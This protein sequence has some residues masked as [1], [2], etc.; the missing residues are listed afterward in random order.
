MAASC[1]SLRATPTTLGHY[2]AS[3]LLLLMYMLM[4]LLLISKCSLAAPP[5]PSPAGKRWVVV[6]DR[7]AEKDIHGAVGNLGATIVNAFNITYDGVAAFEG[8]DNKWGGAGW[9]A[10]CAGCNA[11]AAAA[12]GGPG[13]P[14]KLPAT[15]SARSKTAA[16]AC[17][18]VLLGVC[19]M[20]CLLALCASTQALC[21]VFGGGG[22]EGMGGG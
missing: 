20:L 11:A 8:P 12:P 15:H 19:A 14:F 21:D 10:H 18:V 13:P 7:L 17:A 5:S 16:T 1:C 2:G 9:A 6:Y 4:T 3:P 22:G